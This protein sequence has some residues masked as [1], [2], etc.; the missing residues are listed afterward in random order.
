MSSGANSDIHPSITSR[1]DL[2]VGVLLFQLAI[3]GSA[4]LI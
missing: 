1:V 2:K 3:E 4:W